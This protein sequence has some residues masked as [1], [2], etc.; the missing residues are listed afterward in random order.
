MRP[1]PTVGA[2]ILLNCILVVQF[3]FQFFLHTVQPVPDD[4]IDLQHTNTIFHL[5]LLAVVKIWSTS[6]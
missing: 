6:D 2:Y 4:I 3:I 1:F 5:G